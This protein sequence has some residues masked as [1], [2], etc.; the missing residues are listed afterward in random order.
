MLMVFTL[1]LCSLRYFP[2]F[3]DG[4]LF[5]YS[6]ARRRIMA[7][8]SAPQF[9]SL[10][11]SAHSVSSFAAMYATGCNAALLPRLT[12]TASTSLYECLLGYSACY[13]HGKGA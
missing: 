5:A 3:Q 9:I 2:S 13:Y 4:K 11:R 8:K 7:K 1:Q 6:L 12:N 10:A